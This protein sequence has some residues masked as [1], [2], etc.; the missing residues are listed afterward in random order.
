[1]C[2]A[3]YFASF[4]HWFYLQIVCVSRICNTSYRPIHKSHSEAAQ[5]CIKVASFVGL[6]AYFFWLPQVGWLGI[7]MIGATHRWSHTLGLFS[8]LFQPKNRITVKLHNSALPSCPLCTALPSRVHQVELYLEE[9]THAG[10]WCRKW[11]PAVYHCSTLSE[12]E[13]K[14]KFN[15]SQSVSGV[16]IGEQTTKS[17][18]LLL[19]ISFSFR[20]HRLTRHPSHLPLLISP[21]AAASA[22]SLTVCFLISFPK[23]NTPHVCESVWHMPGT[24]F[25]AWAHQHMLRIAQS[26]SVFL[27]SHLTLREGFNYFCAGYRQR[28]IRCDKYNC[29]FRKWFIRSY[30]SIQLHTCQFMKES[31]REFRREREQKAP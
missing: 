11:S 4:S 6:F 30:F 8:F 22:P 17:R 29:K 12:A 19:G 28:T 1:M 24:K 5:L 3:Q 14:D 7:F 13:E 25:E 26:Q 9:H 31:I 16:K 10:K 23:G 20:P 15:R 18:L 21:Y 2:V 27:L